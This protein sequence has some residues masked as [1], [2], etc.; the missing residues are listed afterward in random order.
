MMLTTRLIGSMILSNHQD[1]FAALGNAFR[2][3]RSRREKIDFIYKSE[4]EGVKNKKGCLTTTQSF[5]NLKSNTMKN[6][7]QR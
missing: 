4:G 3:L 1:V 2:V 7:V 5:V 6:T